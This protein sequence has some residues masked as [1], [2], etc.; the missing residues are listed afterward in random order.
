M[1]IQFIIILMLSLV[2]LCCTSDNKTIQKT[3]IGKYVTYDAETKNESIDPIRTILKFEQEHLIK[4]DFHFDFITDHNEEMSEPYK[5]K[6]N[7]ILLGDDSLLIQS[8]SNDSLVFFSYLDSTEKIVYEQLPKH[9]QA[10][11]EQELFDFLTSNSFLAQVN[12]R[13]EFMNNGRYILD[14][15]NAGGG[16]NQFWRIDKFESE[17]F[18]VYDGPWGT[19]FHIKNFDNKKIA[20]EIYWKEN[21]EFI[22]NTIKRESDFDLSNISG[23]WSR[24]ESPPPPPLPPLFNTTKKFYTEEFLK[25]SDSEILRFDGFK[26]DTFKW[27]INREKDIIILKGHRN[28]WYDRQWNILSIEDDTLILRRS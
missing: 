7:Q 27:E 13:I 18:L 9:N 3:W 15:L 28:K 12:T 25:I 19:V 2:C 14:D 10:H 16:A 21:K 11:R 5:I 20:T 6:A 8:I 22:F 1:K 24:V 17:L 23:E 26:R 4:K